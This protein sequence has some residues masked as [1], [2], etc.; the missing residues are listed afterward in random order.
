MHYPSRIAAL[1]TV[2]MFIRILYRLLRMST[3]FRLPL[4][5][6]TSLH[7]EFSSKLLTLIL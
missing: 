2:F 4:N 3:K 5:L 1:E 7:S 6:L